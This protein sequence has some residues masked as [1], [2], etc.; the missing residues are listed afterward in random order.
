VTE[1]RITAGVLLQGGVP[2]AAA[3]GLVWYVGAHPALN[4]PG[5]VMYPIAFLV[6]L[7]GWILALRGA[8]RGAELLRTAAL[9]TS[10]ALP[11][12][13]VAEGSAVFAALSQQFGGQFHE[14][15][16]ELRQVQDILADAISKLIDSFTA[17][18]SDVRAQ[19]QLA[20]SMGQLLSGAGGTK[21]D[22][23]FEQLMRETSET[24]GTFVDNTVHTS[25]IAMGL[26]DEMDDV[27]RQVASI[28]AILGEIEGI[29]KQTNLLALNAAI[30]AARAGESGRGF[31]V[32]A[33]EV[34]T[35][36][37]R[38]NH[39]SQLIRT[40]MD[41]VHGSLSIA[42]KS[43][44]EMASLDMNFALQ[45]KSS[46]H[47]M[48]GEIHKGNVKVEQS[49]VKLSKI[50]ADVEQN[51]GMAVTTLQFQDMTT[52]LIDHTRMRVQAMDAILQ[53]VAAAS[54]MGAGEDG[55]EAHGYVARLDQCKQ[56][57]IGG[58]AALAAAKSKAVSQESMGTGDV[59]LF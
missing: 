13:V 31:A 9:D 20:I 58:V 25:K 49:M 16:I 42:E 40:H 23:N 44:H 21:G 12:A 53:E 57:V 5:V 34:R 15:N 17:I 2:S 55:V 26:V 54:A 27:N 45:S 6:V 10:V 56:S 11:R 38:T 1:R 35:L 41:K 18:N 52:Q 48:M 51:V 4:W 46:V 36:S 32:V 59:E 29:S 37:L 47:E 7:F 14:A 22:A 24:L 8:L 50:A 39:F 3:L 28:L 33:D 30:E 19:Q 43:I